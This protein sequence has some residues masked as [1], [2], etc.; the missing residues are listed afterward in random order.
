MII[1]VVMFSGHSQT[2]C[3]W[4]QL[5]LHLLQ[6]IHDIIL[7]DISRFGVQ[8]RWSPLATPNSAHSLFNFLFWRRSIEYLLLA[9]PSRSGF[10]QLPLVLVC[11]MFNILHDCNKLTARHT[12]SVIAHSRIY[13]FLCGPIQGRSD[14]LLTLASSGRHTSTAAVRQG[15]RKGDGR[16][17]GCGGSFRPAPCLPCPCGISMLRGLGQVLIQFLRVVHL[18]SPGG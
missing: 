4:T 13:R 3:D 16:L 10:P 5:L 6:E 11:F 18:R 15:G 9:A 14:F 7:G 1:E 17:H 2:F 8:P 12:V